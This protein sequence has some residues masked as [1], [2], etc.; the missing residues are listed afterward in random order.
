M[1]TTSARDIAAEMK[2]THADHWN[3]AK[4]SVDGGVAQI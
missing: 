1:A 2:L 4:T 3:V